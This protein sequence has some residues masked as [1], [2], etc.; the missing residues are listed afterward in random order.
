MKA[1]LG[2]C[3]LRSINNIV[4]VTNYVLFE[5]GQPLHAF[6]ADL[7]E[8]SEIRVAVCERSAKVETL[9]DEEHEIVAGDLTID[10]GAGP[11]ALAGVMGG[12]RTAGCHA[13][14]TNLFLECAYF[15]PIGVRRTARRLGLITDSSYR[16]ERGV[17]PCALVP[18]ALRAAELIVELGRRRNRR[19]REHQLVLLL[20]PPSRSSFD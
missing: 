3:G 17:D 1:R 15:E 12:S 20:H 6:D 19:E 9:D 11:V 4:D 7:L 16:F 18:A 5:T 2:A 13:G 14:T 10:D 8:G